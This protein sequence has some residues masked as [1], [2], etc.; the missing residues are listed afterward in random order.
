MQSIRRTYASDSQPRSSSATPWIVAAAAVATG[1]GGYWYFG[2]NAAD[3]VTAPL[4]EERKDGLTSGGTAKS[5]PAPK[6]AP[7]TFTG[8]DQ[9]FVDLKLARVEPYNHNTKKFVFD[10]PEKDH[11]SGLNVA[12]E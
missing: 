6:D 3:R 4:K 1:V 8:G 5:T 11:V 2:G 12:C 7:K 9:D 10:L